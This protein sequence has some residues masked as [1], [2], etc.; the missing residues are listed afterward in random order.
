MKTFTFALCVLVSAT[1]AAAQ[2]SNQSVIRPPTGDAVPI[3]ILPISPGVPGGAVTVGSEPITV[4]RNPAIGTLE[5][6]GPDGVGNGDAF[7]GYAEPV[8]IRDQPG[9]QKFQPKYVAVF[10]GP[11]YFQTRKHQGPTLGGVPDPEGTFQIYE[12]MKIAVDSHGYYEVS[13]LAHAPGVATVLALQLDVER[14]LMGTRVERTTLSLPPITIEPSESASRHQ[15]GHEL[16]VAR[17]GY[18]SVLRRIVSSEKPEGVTFKRRGR[19]RFGSIPE[20]GNYAS[21]DVGTN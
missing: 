5:P 2:N 9:E 1:E 16:R 20:R 4:H 12:G 21:V 10:E 11:C 17:R 15:P 6:I 18:S 7:S 19:A 13:F 3:D 8:L 14:Q